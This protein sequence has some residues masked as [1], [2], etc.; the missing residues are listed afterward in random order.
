M[1]TNCLR[2]SPRFGPPAA[3]AASFSDDIPALP[4]PELP[5]GPPGPTTAPS[6]VVF[7]KESSGHRREERDMTCCCFRG[8]LLGLAV[9]LLVALS[10]GN[11]QPPAPKG[12]AKE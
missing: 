5:F 4:P 1:G 7:P 11:A 10:A 8:L 6:A 3:G 12:L 2:R 9:V